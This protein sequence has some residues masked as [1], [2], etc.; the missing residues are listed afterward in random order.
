MLGHGEYLAL[1]AACLLITLPLEF[2][3]GARVY[4]RPRR[5][6]L[7][8]LPVAGLF[9]LWDV[10][11]IRRQHWTFDPESTTGVLLPGA[12][13]LEEL[14]F[15][16]VIPTCALLTYEAVGIGLSWIRTWRE[17]RGVAAERTLSAPGEPVGPA[18]PS[19]PAPPAGTALR[20]DPPD[21][22]GSARVD[23]ASPA[24]AARF[25]VAGTVG[26]TDA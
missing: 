12:L 4:R 18:A 14:V 3:W 21:P 22:A 10:L 5:L 2:L 23:L 19:L 16:L 17:R 20:R 1:M 6:A 9:V 11:A 24:A 7:A 13:P 25:G 26:A 8:V 15:F